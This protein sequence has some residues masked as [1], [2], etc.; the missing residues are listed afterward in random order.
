MD[1]RN[2]QALRSITERVA[3]QIASVHGFVTKSEADELE[4][5]ESL[6]GQRWDAFL[7]WTELED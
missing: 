6:V 3:R 1:S 5:L 7:G 4:R 2:R